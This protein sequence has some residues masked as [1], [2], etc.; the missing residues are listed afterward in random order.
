MHI[1]FVQI[2]KKQNSPTENWMKDNYIAKEGMQMASKCP[3]GNAGSACLLVIGEQ[4][5]PTAPSSYHSTPP[6]SYYQRTDDA[7]YQNNQRLTRP[8]ARAPGKTTTWGRS[9]RG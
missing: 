4:Q 3:Q 7:K 2:S 1:T 6:D 8:G 5:V 9:S